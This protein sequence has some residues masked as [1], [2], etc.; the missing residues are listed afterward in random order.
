MLAYA[1]AYL[2]QHRAPDFFASLINNQPMGFYTPA[3]I[4]KDAQRHGVTVK[5]VDVKKSDWR[6]TVLDDKTFRLGFYVVNGLRQ[7]HGEQI[8]RQRNARQ[9]KSLEDFKRRVALSKEE[10]RTLA[11]LGAFNCFAKHRRAAMWNVEEVLHDDLVGNKNAADTAATT[12]T[13][14]FA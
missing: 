12:T 1:S 9:F 6:C 10:M 7:E 5:P 11:E 13:P 3:T 2:K 14:L 8:E 4:V